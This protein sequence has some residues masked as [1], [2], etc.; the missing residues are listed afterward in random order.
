VNSFSDLN[1]TNKKLIK[2]LFVVNG[3]IRPIDGILFDLFANLA[4]LR[5]DLQ[6]ATLADCRTT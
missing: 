2:P 4:S 3:R 1:G 6:S 5:F